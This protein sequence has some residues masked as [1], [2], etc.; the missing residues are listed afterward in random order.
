MY[1]GLFSRISSAMRLFVIIT[2]TAATRPVLARGSKPLADDA[3][4]DARE[5]RAHLGLLDRGEELDEAADGLGRVDG[6][7][8]REH[9]VPR[10][11]RLERRLG[12]LGVA[13][14]AD[15][16]DVGILAEHAAEGLVER[17]GVEPDLPLVDDAAGVVCAGS[18]SDPRS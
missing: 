8:R 10:L 5:D 7:H 11:R 18:R 6:V 1:S 14:L 12:R 13:Q 4:E 2:S 3:L 9:E 17:L 15:Q 16:D